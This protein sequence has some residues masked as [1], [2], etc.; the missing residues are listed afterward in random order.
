MAHS[1]AGD[2]DSGPVIM[3]NYMYLRQIHQRNFKLVI[4]LNSINQSLWNLF[5]LRNFLI[6]SFSFPYRAM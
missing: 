5:N 2:T 1:T 4:A 6:D 3:G